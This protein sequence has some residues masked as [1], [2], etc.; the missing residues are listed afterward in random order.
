M[1]KIKNNLGQIFLKNEKKI[2][3]IINFIKPKKK[4]NLLEIGFG[5]GELTKNFIKFNK[6]LTS[7][8]IDNFL[9]KKNKK[10]FTNFQIINI[11]I[12]K[13]NLFNF[14][15]KKKKKK[16]RIFGNIP[17]NISKKI[18]LKCI[19]N[20]KI[21][22]DIHI[23]IQKELLNSVINNKKNKKYGKWNILINYIFN[24][25]ILMNIK[26]KYFNPKPKI[27]SILI[28]LK[29][30]KNKFKIK[31]LK[32]LIYILNISFKKKNRKIINNLKNIL[33]KKKLNKLKINLN[34]R[35]KEI[36]IKNFCKITN[37]YSKIINLNK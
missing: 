1:L 12:L 19:K 10:K 14:F 28:R 26:K 16:I 2:N 31:K 8:E 21:I 22:K 7:L 13:F 37:L 35:P 5:N 18:L 6:N 15:F 3:K 33:N 29:P 25:K 11:D 24:I 34:Q 23:L 27:D 9:I 36:S 32:H 20:F 4:D 30:K 17:Y